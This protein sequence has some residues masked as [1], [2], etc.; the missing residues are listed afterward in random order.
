MK[1]Y[2]HIFKT[3]SLDP[4]LSQLKLVH[5]V[6]KFLTYPSF[7]KDLYALISALATHLS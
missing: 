3:L 5:S 2:Y 4:T 1:G 7:N 6:T